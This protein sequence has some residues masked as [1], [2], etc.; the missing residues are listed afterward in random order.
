MDNIWADFK[1]SSLKWMFRSIMAL[2]MS[3]NKQVVTNLK[4]ADAKQ[5][6]QPKLEVSKYPHVLGEVEESRVDFENLLCQ[7][8][9]TYLGRK[10]RKMGIKKST[11]GGRPTL[12]KNKK[13]SDGRARRT[14]V[15]DT[16]L[17]L[18]SYKAN[19]EKMLD[20]YANS[21]GVISQALITLWKETYAGRRK[22]IED[23]VL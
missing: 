22:P 16:E 13:I 19:N 12:N 7:K 5:L 21:N 6:K 8:I 23:G 4:E 20:L 9:L 10:R 3:Q 11:K 18:V 2:S 1:N 17:D 14:T 15:G